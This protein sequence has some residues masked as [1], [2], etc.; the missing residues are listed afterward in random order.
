MLTFHSLLKRIDKTNLTIHSNKKNAI[1]YTMVTPLINA[2][3]LHDNTLY[4][5]FISDLYDICLNQSYVGFILIPDLPL[6]EDIHISGEFVI[7]DELISLEVLYDIVQIEFRKKVELASNMSS[8]FSALIKG[9][10][11]KELIDIGTKI[12]GNPIIV[13]NSAY[14]VLAMSNFHIDE[15]FWEF[16]RTHGY[17][18]QDS[19]NCYKNE[20]ITK[21]VI[22]SN[23]PVLFTDGVAKKINIIS[24]KLTMGNQI[25]GYIGVH[26]INKEFSPSDIDT[27]KML[28]D[29][30]TV[31]IRTDIYEKAITHTVHEDIIIDLLNG[32]I[33]A[34]IILSDRLHN[35]NWSLKKYFCLVKIPLFKSDQSISFLD[36]LYTKLIERCAISKIARYHESLVL[37]INYNKQ[38]EY[39]IELNNIK[40]ILNNNNIKG[41]ISRIFSKSEFENLSS[42]YHQAS[43]AYEIGTLTNKASICIYPYENVALFHL[44]SKIKDKDELKI[45]CHPSYNKL[46]KHDKLNGTEY[47]KT[48]YEYIL[49]ANNISAAAD[50][51]FIHR[52]TMA[53]R[54]NKISEITDLDLT[55]G[56]NIF[57]LYF[58]QKI[59]EWLKY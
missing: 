50:K 8:I 16:A 36:Y 17:C 13:T 45:F 51:L 29:I 4:V 38:S 41:G 44:F 27:V 49:C 54:L 33:P 15:P 35:A 42:Y 19:I 31:A 7:W 21:K 43:I 10:S 46:L 2:S 55:N 23:I 47:C 48:I 24:N 52:N 30:F 40:D 53:Y 5:G 3:P 14:K 11:L 56:I 20:G 58:S 9:H 28:S 25:L 22:E 59:S 12:L 1:Q 39:D 26:A 32:E 18:C 6:K 34:T 57:K 37:I